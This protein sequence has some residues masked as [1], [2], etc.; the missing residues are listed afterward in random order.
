M[1]FQSRNRS[2]TIEQR[3]PSGI[4]LRN[5]IRVTLAVSSL[6]LGAIFAGCGSGSSAVHIGP[7][8][9][10]DANGNQ[11]GGTHTTLDLGATIY[12]DAALSGNGSSLGVDWTVNCGSAPPPGTPLPPGQTENQECGWFTPVH[13]ST[14]P[15]PDYAS[16]G[17]GIVTLFT[18]PL[19]P[20]KEGVVTLFAAPTANHATYSAI[21]I[22]I[23]ALPISIN[24]APAPPSTLPVSGTASL[25]A[26]LTNDYSSGGANWTASCGSSDCGSFSAAQTASGVATTYTAPASVPPGG[27]VQVTATSV[28][29]PTKFVTASISILP[30]AVTI[31]QSAQSVVVDGSA[32]FTAEVANDV[33]NSGVNWT[34][35]CGTSDDCGSITGQTATGIAATYTAPSAVPGSA[36]VQV[37]ATS[38]ADPAASAT[39]TVTVTTTAGEVTGQ[40]RAGFLPV[41][42]ASIYLY[43]AG[44]AGYGSAATLLNSSS[45]NAVRTDREGAFTVRA[46]TACPTATSELY[47]VAEGGDAGEGAHPGLT[48]TAALGACSDSG[49]RR[50]ITIN[51]VSTLAFA[52]SLSDFIRD[53]EHV[54]TIPGNREGLASA[55]AE[56]T[57]LVDP[58]TGEA[59]A[60]TPAGNGT[61]PQSEIN[62]L[63]NILHGC[64]VMNSGTVDDGSPCG[65]IFA[66]GGRSNASTLRA[67]L[68]FARQSRNP[69]ETESPLIRADASADGPFTPALRT[70]SA[71]WIIALT[72]TA[73]HLR[74]SQA[75][76][77]DPNGNV[78]IDSDGGFTELDNLGA[79][80][81]G[82]PFADIPCGAVP[83][84]CG[85]VPALAVDASGNRW[86]L[87]GDGAS[88][89]EQIG[90]VN[91]ASV[92]GSRS[93]KS[94]GQE[95]AP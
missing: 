52:Y 23:L 83:A 7:I 53:A 67:A 93:A 60:V 42:G 78:W 29:D 92:A 62:T 47:L 91:P 38:M 14:A 35:A 21:T 73:R 68:Y 10:V 11:L 39:A 82:S 43:A 30:V 13:T 6:A 18:A 2:Q 81:P 69:N 34:L 40:V 57:N 16:S 72:F 51:E 70:E 75:L 66:S 80:V 63:A 3:N 36:A 31:A 50:S 22:T 49:S 17:A 20:P 26:V 74:N 88:V 79:E 87:S 19:A 25:K 12:V 48:L 64:A 24:F 77:V 59:R 76:G 58:E 84:R 71:N 44:E 46:D 89:T 5:V 65:R 33:T 55:L 9:F 15:V 1:N 54:G 8:A 41:S 45:R 90:A 85:R 86:T 94:G 28:T 56:T 61:V 37:T 32:L 27:S 4:S 95:D